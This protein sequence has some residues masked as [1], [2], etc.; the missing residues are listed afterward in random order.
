[1]KVYL[2]ACCLSRLTDDQ[3]QARIREES[4]AVER[5]LAGVRRGVVKLVVSEALEDEVR[6]NH[7]MERRIEAQAILS[8]AVERIGIHAAIVSRARTLVGVGYGPYDALHIAAAES[9]KVDSL[10]TTDDGLL[11]RSARKLGDLR[12]PVR[13]PVS[14]VKEQAL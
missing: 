8:P 4:Q 3:S 6:R 5:V 11:K 10:L 13:N 12:I 9:L 14:W 2:D 7:S 1:M